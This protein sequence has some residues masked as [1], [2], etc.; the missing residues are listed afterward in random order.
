MKLRILCLLMSLLPIVPALSQEVVVSKSG[1]TKVSLD[2]SAYGAAGPGGAVFRQT[3][4]ADLQRCGWFT[5]TR[6][7]AFTVSGACRD[8]GGTLTAE[9][10]VTDVL[11]STVALNKAYSDRS[12]NARHLAHQ[13]ADDIILAVKGFRGLCSGRIVMVGNRT[14]NKELYLCDAD[15]GNLRQLTNDRSISMAPRW[16]PDGSRIVYTSFLKGFA[17]IYMIDTRSGGRS[18][19]ARYPG[20]N[21]AGGVSPSGGEMLM[22]LSRDGNPE[23][24]SKSFAAGTLTR[25]TRTP[26]AGEASPTW[27]P[28]GSQIAYVSDLAGAGSP[29]IY[30]MDRGGNSRRLTSRGRENVDPDWGPNNLIAFSSRRGGLY[31]I[32]I[33]NPSSMDERQ[34]SPSDA[35]Y[36]DPC[37]A[38]D[39]RH[40]VCSRRDGGGSRIYLLD[41]L[42]DP[43]VCLTPNGGGWFS[44]SWCS[45]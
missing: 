40:L 27:S 33:I 18:V 30:V 32:F 12:D 20:I 4:V 3:L 13:V 15:G 36:E 17:D 10:Q 16:S 43:P 24:Y 1:G 37:W 6:P 42:G 35:N 8:T 7:A 39:G 29:Q 28:D 23:V 26:R 9:C 22:V 38:S 19:L 2:L 11:K 25:L 44:P 21:M 45:K 31:G 41:T 5:L 34:I 14:G